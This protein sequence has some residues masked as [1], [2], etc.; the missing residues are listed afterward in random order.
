[1]WP[2]IKI[3]IIYLQHYYK[4]SN[5][6]FPRELISI[7]Y[8]QFLWGRLYVQFKCRLLN[9]QQTVIYVIWAYLAT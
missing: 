8:A 1:M 6:Y 7:R 4:P 2:D 9:M 3:I 5:E